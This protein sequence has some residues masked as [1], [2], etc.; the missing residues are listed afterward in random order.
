[1]N[2]HEQRVYNQLR[3]RSNSLELLPGGQT[4]NS[5]GINASI[6]QIVGNPAFKAEISLQIFVRYYSQAVVGTPAAV[7]PPAGQ[8]TNLPLYLFG[9]IDSMA[10][11]ARARQLVPGG[12]GWTYADMAVK[13][14][15]NNSDDAFYYP[16]P[17]AAAAVGYTSGSVFNNLTLP[18][19]MLFMIPMAGFVAGAAATTVCA[20]ILVRCPNVPYASL[21]AALGSDLVTLNMIRY[22]VPAAA[23]AQLAQQITFIKGSLF[24]KV[25]TDTLDPQTFITPGTFQPQISDIP[26]TL[27]IDKNLIAATQIIYTAVVPIQF[28]WTVTVSAIDKLTQG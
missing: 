3:G 22:V 12:A 9:N 8:Q 4:S 2:A 15:G 28:T 24:G 13:R 19:D 16:L 14:I 11:Y 7:V 5:S 27:P 26:I 6:Q 1:M 20:E 21:L 17:H 23:V 18:G 10:N 25:S